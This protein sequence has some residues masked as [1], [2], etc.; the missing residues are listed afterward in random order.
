M[1][2]KQFRRR[3]LAVAVL[4]ALMVAGMG[5]TLY[6]LQINNGADYYEQSQR[7]VAETQTVE[8]ARGQILDRNGQVLVSNRVVYQVTLDTSRMGSASK[9]NQI[10]L[11][12]LDKNQLYVNLCD[13]EDAEFAVSPEDRAFNRSFY[14]EG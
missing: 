4:L 13:M 6:D 9:R 14:G 12:L 5:A 7:R 11:E 8:S 1:D 3:A 10:L 2:P